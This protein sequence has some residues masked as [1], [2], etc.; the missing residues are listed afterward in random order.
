MTPESP[1]E[2]QLEEAQAQLHLY[3]RDLQTLVESERQKKAQ[4]RATNKQLQAYARDFRTA[5]YAEQQKAREL[6]KAYHDTIL[7]LVKAMRYKDDETGA[8]TM[9]ISHYAKVVALHLGWERAEA[10]MLFDAAPMHDVG[11]IGIP[12][13]I[14][15][16]SGALSEAEWEVVRRHPVIGAALLQGSPSALLN[17][18]RIIALGHHER[19]DGSGYPNGTSGDE[20]S[21]AARIVMLVDQYDALRTRRPY[22]PAHPHAQVVDILVNGDGRTLPRHFDPELLQV[23]RDIHPELEVIYERYGD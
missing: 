6:E 9:R 18:A 1:I 2:K 22:K 4:L 8:H 7:R 13:S 20:T 10:Q 23:F 3:A 5:F 21:Q 14:L 19:W 15:L 11:K 12:E 17:Q 16:K